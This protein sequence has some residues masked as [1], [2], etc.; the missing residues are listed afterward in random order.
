M[1]KEHILVEC[2]VIERKAGFEAS[3]QVRQQE[4]IFVQSVGPKRDQF[5]LI[6]IGL[7]LTG[8]HPW[9]FSVHLTIN[10]QILCD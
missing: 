10:K 4:E 2:M 6:L 3:A 9:G 8:R 5:C 1:D 7:D